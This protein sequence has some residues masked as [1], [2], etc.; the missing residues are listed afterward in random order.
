VGKDNL[1]GHPNGEVISRLKE[2]LGSEKNIYRTD[3]SGTIEFTTD[4]QRLWVKT[5]HD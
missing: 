2:S 1:F 5:E 3:Q 4:G